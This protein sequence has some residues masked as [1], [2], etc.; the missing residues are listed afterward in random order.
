M[1]FFKSEGFGS[2]VEELMRQN[3]VPGISIAI[4]QD[5]QVASSA[6]G[7]ATLDPETACTADSLFDIASTSKSFTA[8]SVALLVDD[9]EAFPEV[10]Y[11]AVMSKLLP[12]DF[13][14]PSPTYT[15]G[16]VL[17]DLLGH[18]TGMPG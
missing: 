8:A 10:Q 2:H 15:E 6:Y 3:H 17:D 12:D 5:D 14:M 7:F 4:V 18:T 1:E 13:V 11:D 9:D 16:V